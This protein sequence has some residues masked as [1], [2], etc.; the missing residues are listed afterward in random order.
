MNF[1]FSEEQEA[2]RETLRRFLEEK[3]PSAE[4][5]RLMETAEG[6]DPAAWKQMAEELGLQGVHVPEAYGGQGFGFLELGIVLEEM[7]RT[8]V[9]TPYFSSAC[10]AT[11]AV[12]N[13]GSEE[14]RAALLPGLASGE[15]IG[16][17]ALLEP[18]GDWDPAGV[19]LAYARDG[20]QFLLSGSKSCVTDGATAD[21]LVVAARRPGSRAA[22]GVT[23]FTVRGDAKGLAAAPVDPLD[24]TRK[25]ASLE[26]SGVRA[27]LLG[28]E[29]EALAALAKTLDQAC[30]CLALEST[31]GAERCLRSAVD[32]AKQRVQFG[33]PIG[34]FQAVK[35]KCAEVLLEL[36]SAR[37][38]AYYASCMASEDSGE[39]PLAASLAKACCGDAFLRAAAENIH[40]H[41]GVGF[42][43]ESDAH[44]YYKRAKANEALFGTPAFHRRRIAELLGF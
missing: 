25:L 34:S 14:Q 33:R 6:Y 3:S 32:Y 26:F 12:L 4:V 11:N 29:G 44:L 21:L 1:A 20:D 23:L 39:L 35:H 24:A 30:A 37:S 7:G 36:E 10:L 43:W 27:E 15:T 38:A 5:F 31:G 2:F 17:L 9:C 13:A 22:D 8:L 41:G 28:V 16:T 42:T 18:G 19:A 40:I